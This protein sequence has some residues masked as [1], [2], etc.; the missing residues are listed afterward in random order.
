MTKSTVRLLALPFCSSLLLVGVTGCSHHGGSS[1]DLLALVL[2]VIGLG[3]L[4][5]T[6]FAQRK[7]R[8]TVRVHRKRRRRRTTSNPDFSS[9]LRDEDDEEPLEKAQLSGD[10]ANVDISRIDYWIKN[11]AR[12]SDTVRSIIKKA[13]KKEVV[14][15]K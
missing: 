9:A 8:S 13:R 12:P 5:I 2:V 4:A 14:A 7:S 11:G 15:A 10:N 6:I 3:L 1:V